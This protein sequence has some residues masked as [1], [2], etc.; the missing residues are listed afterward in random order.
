M[1]PPMA[2]SDAM[3]IDAVMERIRPCYDRHVPGENIEVEFRF[4]KFNGSFFDT[5]V[6]ATTFRKVYEGL[7]Q[8]LGWEK[9]VNTVQDVY[10]ADAE[11]VRMS[12]DGTTEERSLIRKSK[13]EQVDFTGIETSPFDVRFSV[14]H[15][16]P[17]QGEFAM[18][19]KRM[20]QRTSFIRKN[21][22]IDMTVSTGA[23]FDKD[24]ENPA[25]YQIEMEIVDPSEISCEEEL[26]NIAYKINDIMRILK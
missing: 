22:S 10:Y 6:G 5:N 8:F 21:L 14:N 3:N 20:K 1:S 17:L 12:V 9:V 24:D 13:V 18:D 25:C 11:N 19:R 7:Q 23:A 4:G 2:E 15:E 16:E 26:Y